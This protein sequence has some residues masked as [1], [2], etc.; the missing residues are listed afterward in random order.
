[1]TDEVAMAVSAEAD[2][3]RFATTAPLTPQARY[4]AT[5]WS[6]GTAEQAERMWARRGAV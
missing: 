5:R 3:T 6:R 1:M 2:Q 4:S